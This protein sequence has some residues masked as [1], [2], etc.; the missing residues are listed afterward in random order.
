[1]QPMTDL[2][3]RDDFRNMPL[4]KLPDIQF[5]GEGAPPD[6]IEGW[7]RG[8]ILYR[9]LAFDAMPDET[10]PRGWWGVNIWLKQA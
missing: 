1:M 9:Q 8:D 2:D 7:D 10:N 3:P 6:E 4:G 5:G